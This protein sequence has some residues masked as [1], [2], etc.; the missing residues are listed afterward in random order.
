ML[1][2]SMRAA[3][4]GERCCS[5]AQKSFKGLS[6]LGSRLTADTKR[7]CRWSPSLDLCEGLGRL[8]CSLRTVRNV[9]RLLQS[10]PGALGRLDELPV[11]QAHL[12]ASGR[13]EQACL[14]HM[15]CPDG[16]MLLPS[17]P[18]ALARAQRAG[19]QIEG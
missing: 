5:V 17:C 4:M 16:N 2:C 18:Q 3:Q 8:G 12:T 15:G 9:K 10:R 7:V 13:M 1:G 6:G 19:Q 14:Q 11:M